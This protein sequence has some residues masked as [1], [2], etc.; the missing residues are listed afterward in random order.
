MSAA[1]AAE[2]GSVQKNSSTEVKTARARK[3]IGAIQKNPSVSIIT[4]PA[5]TLHINGTIMLRI[6]NGDFGTYHTS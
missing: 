1:E 5:K 4:L 2:R 3:L 6:V